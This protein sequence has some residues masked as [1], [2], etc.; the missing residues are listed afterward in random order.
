MNSN[1]LHSNWYTFIILFNSSKIC[2]VH[3]GDNLVSLTYV[4]KIKEDGMNFAVVAKKSCE[5]NNHF[6]DY[7][8]NKK[9]C[10][11]KGKW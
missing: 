1:T 2:G 6:N 7:G 3:A 8:S 9:Y 4:N 10:C 5:S 11:G